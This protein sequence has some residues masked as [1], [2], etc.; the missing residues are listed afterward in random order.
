M[1][2]HII[3]HQDTT[4]YAPASDRWC[5]YLDSYDGS[6]GQFIGKGA[7]EA[8]AISDLEQQMDDADEAAAAARDAACERC[9]GTGWFSVHA[10]T[11]QYVCAGAPPDYAQSHIGVACR[12]CGSFNRLGHKS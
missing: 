9:E 3:T 5:A 1:A 11:Y 4:G 10:R 8:E 6:P 12:E 2:Q 7:T